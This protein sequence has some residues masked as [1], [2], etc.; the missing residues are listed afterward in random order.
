M[1]AQIPRITRRTALAALATT[2]L[3]TTACGNSNS[4][5]TSG[6]V[7]KQITMYYPIQVGGASEKI[8]TSLVDKFMNANPEIDVKSVYSGNYDQTLVAVQT[9]IDGGDAPATAVL[10]STSMF[11][12]INDKLIVPFDEVVTTDEDRAWLDSFYD[13]FM[14][15]SRDSKGRTWGIPFQRS[16]LVQYWNKEQFKKAGLDPDHAPQTWDE[17]VHIAKTVQHGSNARWGIEIPSDG[18]YWLFQGLAIQN[19][20]ELAN[21]DGTEVYFDKPAVIEALEFWRSLSQEY[22][23]HPPDIVAWGTTPEDFFRGQTA[24]MWHSTGNL[25]N[26]RDHAPFEFGVDMLP[27][28]VRRGSPTGGGN[29]YLFADASDAE[30]AAAM[31]LIRSLTSPDSAAKWCIGT[32]YVAPSPAAWETAAMKDYVAGFPAA[33]VARDQLKYAVR[34]LATYEEGRIVQILSDAIQAGLVGDATPAD[35]LHDAQKQATNVL[36]PY[37]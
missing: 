25:T 26:V 22:G 5:E 17:L 27:K 30:R 21:A 37:K 7:A 36:T 12:L 4:T 8:M 6:D 16:T 14:L 33:T 19:G 10:T 13:A 1:H 35:A 15:N 2:P 3:L 18:P 32:G 9:A 11:D 31:R 24:M 23:V 29:F 28:H 20:I 34:E